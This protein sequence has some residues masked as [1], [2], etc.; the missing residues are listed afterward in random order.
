MKIISGFPY[1]EVQFT[2]DG[3]VDDAAE[4]KAVRGFLTEP[5]GTDLLVIS[6]GWNNDM[7]D[8]RK[9]YAKFL[10]CLRTVLDEKAV[11]KIADRSFAVLAVL[12]PSMKFADED[13]IPSG[14][15]AIGSVVTAALVK[16]QLDRL[17]AAL[18]PSGKSKIKSARALL[19]SLTNDPKAR[20]KFADLIRA[21]LP[22]SAGEEDDGSKA[23][24][25]RK[26]GDL[27]DRLSKPVSASVARPGRGG[28]A[29][30]GAATGGAAGGIGDAF[31]GVLSGARNLLNYSTYYLMKERAGTVGRGGVNGVLRDLKKARPDLHVHL[32]G[33]SFGG[34]LVTAAADGPSGKPS[35]VFDTMTLLQ[36][37]F[38]QNGF[39]VK[40]DGARNGAFRSVVS[41][42]KISGPIIITH[43]THDR[44]VGVA[45][46]L[47]S[48][49]AGQD[50]SAIG[51]ASDRFGGMGSNGAQHTPESV[52]E[53]LKPVGGAYTFAKGKVYNLDADAIIEDHS[54]ICHDEVA[55]ALLKAVA[56]S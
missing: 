40:F 33:H 6:H 47:A 4:V 1:F 19:P 41:A 50:A 43:S 44:A 38:S 5:N 12:W 30:I 16:K 11:P 26:G 31:S 48:R 34:R 37:A 2:K 27:M 56:V 36:A 45:Y 55:F 39:A 49:I 3:D 14:A 21:A 51:D 54:D 28:A 32:A 22:K 52:D 10:A 24:F 35:I 18:G 46:P 9:L 7:N 53:T 8:A 23:F 15:A 29:S 42:H 25:K 20:E 13:L 17:D